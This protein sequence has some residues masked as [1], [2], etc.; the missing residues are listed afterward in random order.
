MTR[1]LNVYATTNAN[2]R[3]VLEHLRQ[4][5]MSNNTTGA[6]IF[7][8][9]NIIA[10]D[11]VPEI[12]TIMKDAEQKI[13]AQQQQEQQHQQQMQEQQIQAEQ[14]DKQAEQAFTSQE[15]EKQIR[16]DILV[17]EIRAAGYGSMMDVNENKQSDYQDAMK[18]IR[19]SE[20]YQDQA[21]LNREKE[22]NKNIQTREKINIE[23]EKIQSAQQIANT[24]LDIA[25]ENKNQYDVKSDKKEKDS[26]T[27]K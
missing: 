26:K 15:S 22:I 12:K 1:D 11:S 21:N 24:Q 7:D 16:K 8:L 14:Q 9:G 13:Q 19:E 23:R 10:A 2:N 18:D 3:A 20:R 25:R 4:L 6:S 5:A 27:K 17:A